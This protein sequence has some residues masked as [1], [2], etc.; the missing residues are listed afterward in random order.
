MGER[1]EL[2]AGA[3]EAQLEPS[4]GGAVTTLRHEGTD[5]LRPAPEGANHPLDAASFPLVP[6]ANRIAHGRFA[7]AGTAHQIPLN[8]GEHPHALH[9]LGWQAAWTVE[10][11][12]PTQA[13]LTHS[14]PGGGAWP[15]PYDA[16]QRIVLDES[17]LSITLSVTNRAAEPAPVGL[18]FHPYFHAPQGTRLTAS[19]ESVWLA[20]ATCI[21]T[22]RAPA[23]H[24]GDWS[25]GESVAR[26]ELIDHAFSG[27][28]GDARIARPDLPAPIRLTASPEL[29]T[30][31]L[32]MPPGEPFF[33]AEPVGNMPDAPNRSEAGEGEA[34]RSLA[35]GE[36]LAVSMRIAIG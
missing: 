7:W 10:S 13:V 36:A 25:M 3:W 6:F 4:L 32:Y 31:H 9:G 5:I 16:E 21:P 35:P 18:G 34:M 28:D 12:S 2:R 23:D 33:C 27:W 14:H 15:W 29:S 26:A 30:L 22:G 20:D 17:G 11:A 24:F 1:L 8:F 19:L